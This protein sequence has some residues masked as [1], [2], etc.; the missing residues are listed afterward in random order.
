MA[1]DWVAQGPGTH[2]AKG[3]SQEKAYVTGLQAGNQ[4]TA[5]DDRKSDK[6]TMGSIC[7]IHVTYYRD[8]YYYH[9][10]YYDIYYCYYYYDHYYYCYYYYCYC[11]VTHWASGLY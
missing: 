9:Y 4:V 10:Y 1:G 2:G 11:D 5:N 6:D 8:Y 7:V 3:L